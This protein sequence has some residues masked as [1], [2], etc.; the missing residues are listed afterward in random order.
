MLPR[1]F[2]VHASRFGSLVSVEKLARGDP[3]STNG[4]RSPLALIARSGRHSPRHFQ[5]DSSHVDAEENDA[6][7]YGDDHVAT[8]RRDADPLHSH[9]IRAHIADFSRR[10]A[11]SLPPLSRFPF[12]H[13]ALTTHGH[14]TRSARSET[15][16]PGFRFI[17]KYRRFA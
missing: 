7:L 8:I 16:R 5:A 3:R 1:D 15:K 14:A 6:V 10:N 13:D 2:S 11:D 4:R 9:E 12:E 17:L